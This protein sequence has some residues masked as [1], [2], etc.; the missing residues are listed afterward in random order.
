MLHRVVAHGTH[1]MV[2]HRDAALHSFFD[3]FVMQVYHSHTYDAKIV[4]K[5]KSAIA[6]DCLWG[7]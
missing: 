1:Q 2:M 3:I 4:P 5:T 6:G 7:R